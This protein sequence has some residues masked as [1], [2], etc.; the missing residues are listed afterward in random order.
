[1]KSNIFKSFVAAVAVVSG[2][3][4]LTGCQ[5]H[6]DDWDLA[7]P[8][9]ENKANISILDFKKEFW[10]ESDNYCIEIP[11]RP[12][13][14]HYIISGR[15]VSS[16]EQ[17]NVFKSLYIQDETGVM[18]L[19]INQYSLYVNNRIGQEIV[20][21]LTGLY[22]G[23]YAAQ[24][25]V[26]GISFDDKT[27]DASTYFMAPEIY[28]MHREYN[29]MPEPEKID[30]LLVED[31]S[32]ISGDDI[33]KW[34]GQLV[35][36]NNV[37]F[38]N[39]NNPDNNQLCNEYHSS[40]YSQKI[41][42][43]F[44]SVDIRTSGYSTFW[45]M[46]LP[47]KACDVVGILASYNS[48]WQVT[49]I[50]ANG[51]MNVGDPTAWGIKTKPYTVE[52]ALGFADAD[53]VTGWVKG[54]I[55][56]TIQPEITTV[57]SNA[58]IQWAGTEPFIIDSYVVIAQT[59]DVR[60]YTQC[61]LV[62]L[63][64][65]TPLYTYVNLADHAE[66]AGRWLNIRGR[67][68]RDMGMAALAGNDGAATSFQLEGVDVPGSEE[69]EPGDDGDGSEEKP[70]TV[71]QAIANNSGTAWVKGI[72]VGC[73][74]SNNNYTLEVTAPFTVASNVYIADKATETNTA[75]MLPIQLVAGTDIRSAVNLVDNPANA[76]KTL[77][78][79]GSLERYFQQPGLKSPTAYKLDGQGGGDTP[80]T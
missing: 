5:D 35:R 61:L 75:K 34:Q 31:L 77:A 56:G 22:C 59:P 25:Q 27:G 6:F 71:A 32:S 53:N 41:T 43:S 40:G 44:G 2:A 45:N 37:T 26:G 17:S 49:L 78:I 50:D 24:F 20:I 68:S 30:T 1:M 66:N 58:D 67:F 54:Y 52:Q 51:I 57:S 55:V 42:G 38:D 80:V 76:G 74:N 15:V 13:G 9:A 47:T 21:D 69:P 60:D 33:L 79:Q 4:A 8:V 39:A 29:G 36:F 48:N 18:P 46:K 72:I 65:G 7:S 10:Q 16:D 28:A 19:S 70:Y 11:A 3:A 64:S 62:P 12:D 23:R 63:A 73:M 14:S